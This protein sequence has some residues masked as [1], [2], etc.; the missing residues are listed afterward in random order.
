M[1]ESMNQNKKAS[2]ASVNRSV[3][4]VDMSPLDNYFASVAQA[5]RIEPGEFTIKEA[6]ERWSCGWTTAKERLNKDVE[7][8]KLKV[9]KVL[10]GKNHVNAY[11]LV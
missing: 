5:S 11:S 1:K 4:K 6:M 2:S 3:V 9:R 8:G 10:T 7:G